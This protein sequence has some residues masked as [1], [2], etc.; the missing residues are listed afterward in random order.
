MLSA[1]GAS[2][3][4]GVSLG[5]TLLAVAVLS[6]L[7]FTLA[8]LCVTH[9]RLTSQQDRGTLASNAA[10]SAI[11]EAISKVLQDPS[12]GKSRLASDVVRVETREA[13]GIVTFQEDD[14]PFSTNNLEGTE[15]VPGADG[16]LV[17]AATVH[18]RAVGRSG[19]TERRIEAV[20]RL[21]PFPWAV[22]SG[23][24]IVTRNGVLVAALADDT[25]PPSTDPE[26]LL[27][28]DLIANGSGSQA[29]VLGNDST[30]LG[31]VETPGQVVLGTDK[32]DIR[33]EIRAGSTPVEL[34]TLRP[35][36]H[37]PQTT[38]ASHFEFTEGDA[39]E[40]VGSARAAGD[41]TFSEPLKL[42]NAQLFVDGDLTL[43][44]GVEGT[45]MLVATGDIT[46]HSGVQLEGLTELAV[47]SGGRVRLRGAGESRSLVR[48]FFYAEQGLEAA[49]ITLV[50]S[51]LTGSASTGVSLDRVNVLYEEPRTIT[52][53]TANIPSQTF[54]IG[55]VVPRSDGP[56]LIAGEPTTEFP[57][58]EPAFVLDVAPTGSGYPLTITFSSGHFVGIN[59]TIEVAHGEDLER[60]EG[61]LFNLMSSLAVSDE[62]ANYWIENFFEHYPL[63][64]LISGVQGVEGQ[65]GGSI[66]LSGDI[67]QFLPIEDRIRIVSW[68]E[69]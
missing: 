47:I 56:F 49:E 38:G 53:Q 11:S 37:D 6:L 32:M 64:D 13:L 28:A 45:G 55:T 69:Y 16:A 25:W 21:P 24:E 23:G 33:G 20:L 30:V 8:G 29:I 12:F 10:R 7:A 52:G 34:P 66:V 61:I 27:P 4:R 44:R 3:L 19:G 2:K 35:S 62:R 5:G 14:L 36:D 63:E 17:P 26:D 60:A 68:V 31:D 15:D 65:E 46:V 22:A 18:L 57:S 43:R 58:T 41:I 51:L 50:G 48:G 42:S 54:Y 59:E 1:M 67:S 40:I 9:L 39:P